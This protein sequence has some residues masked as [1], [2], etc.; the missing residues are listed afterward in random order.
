MKAKLVA[1]EQTGTWQFVDLPPNIKPIGCKWVCNIIH[2]FDG[3][4]ERFKSHLVSKGYN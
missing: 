1:L 3:N 4:I 2:K